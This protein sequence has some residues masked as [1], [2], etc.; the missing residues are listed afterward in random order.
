MLCLELCIQVAQLVPCHLHIATS[1]H[2]VCLVQGV[3]KE[4]LILGV[5]SEA[6]FESTADGGLGFSE[7]HF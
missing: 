6:A 5:K 2:D 7:P 3:A 4:A 1:C